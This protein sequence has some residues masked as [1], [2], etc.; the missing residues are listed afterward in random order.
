MDSEPG[1]KP[2]PRYRSFA[3]AA[4]VTAVGVALISIALR[5][6]IEQAGPVLPV[7]RRVAIAASS[8]GTR[9]PVGH[10]GLLEEQVLLPAR[11]AGTSLQGTA[12]VSTTLGIGGP[13]GE[14]TPTA[15]SGPEGSATPTP[16]PTP[17][18]E[19]GR[20][21]IIVYTVQPGDNVFLIARR[22]G[23][24]QDTIVWANDELAADP[25][26]LSVGQKL[27]ILPVDGVLHTV[28]A[29]E[30]LTGIAQRYQVD[31]Q[32]II[33]YA[34]NGIQN[35]EALT[36]GQQLIIPGGIKPAPKPSAPAKS[37]SVAQPAVASGG[38][39]MIPAGAPATPVEAPAATFIWPT[40][41]MISQSF[42]KYH[43]A[44][45]IASNQSPPILAAA[46]GTVTFA[47]WSGGLGNA[48]QIDHGN[49]FVTTYG[50]LKSIAVH[51][52]QAVK[53]GQQI[54]VMGSTGHSTGPHLH[55]IVQ[56]RGG[57]LNPLL[58]L[59]R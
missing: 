51:A 37:A 1:H 27:N 36:V 50:H 15:P 47:G 40:K 16:L 6:P 53:Q 34:A 23:L 18:A 45:D 20:S 2:L 10:S 17:T 8:R 21:G 28:K 13:E 9:P 12:A 49:G 59:P 41:G 54:G 58:Y 42:G 48:I 32:K 26:Q 5:Q 52:G 24:S 25:D 55:F 33:G 30:T 11:A 43:G 3:A 4:T 35:P 57:I 39:L 14:A 56:Y 7:V 46:D 19:A 44:I 31:L 29:G 22:F 38:A